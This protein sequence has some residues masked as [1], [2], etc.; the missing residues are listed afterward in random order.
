M[1]M[2]INKIEEEDFST[3][4]IDF[5]TELTH[6]LDLNNKESIIFPSTEISAINVDRTFN[7]NIFFA[8]PKF[9]N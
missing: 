5:L 6:K 3:S 1:S 7:T 2:K 9:K 4:N 8:L